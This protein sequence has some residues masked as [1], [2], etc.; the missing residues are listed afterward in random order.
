MKCIGIIPARFQSTRFPGKPLALIA[1]QSMIQRVYA[2]VS[3]CK[4]LDEVVV[5]TDDDRIMQEVERFG[6]QA[7]LTRTDHLSGTDRVAEAAL[8]FA[9]AEVVVNIQ[10]DEPFI[11]PEQID[12]LV[13][14]F[15]RP[16]VEIGTLARPL[17]ESDELFNPNVVKVVFGDQGNALYFSRSTI[18][19]LRGKEPAQWIEATAH[20]QHLGL[21]AY[22]ANVLQEL[23]QL[24]PGRLEQMESLEQLRWLEAGYQIFVARTP[25]RT[26][27]IDTPEDLA[28]AEAWLKQQTNGPGK[29]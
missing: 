8:A 4:L 1:G 18:P 22:R 20:F 19:H 10:G 29:A 9:E 24:P 14:L 21:Y 13:Q 12:Q 25:N 28:R 23:T 2:Q 11:D 7:V 17:S 27:G 5:A 3:G 15:N 6:G 16:Q 26:I